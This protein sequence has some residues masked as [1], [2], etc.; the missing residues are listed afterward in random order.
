MVQH[1]SEAYEN[2]PPIPQ[3]RR[4]V[5][6]EIIHASHHRQGHKE[7]LERPVLI[8]QHVASPPCAKPSNGGGKEGQGDEAR[9]GKPEEDGARRK[10]SV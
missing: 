8:V 1:L 3:D 9:L 4:I 7:N 2:F 5:K 6:V 10:I